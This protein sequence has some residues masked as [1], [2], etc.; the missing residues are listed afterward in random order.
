LSVS[1]IPSCHF[2]VFASGTDPYSYSDELGITYSVYTD[3][4]S[5]TGYE[6]INTELEIPSEICGVPVTEI[7]F[8]AFYESKIY[9]VTLPETVTKIGSSAF[10]NSQLTSITMPDSITSI[11]AAAFYGTK[12]RSLHLPN[13][14]TSIDPNMFTNCDE[15]IEVTLPDNLETIGQ[16]AFSGCVS[17]SGEIMLPSSVKT[18]ESFAFENCIALTGIFFSD[19]I[20]QIKEGAFQNCQG[21][22]GVIF[23]DSVKSIEKKAFY[24]CNN[25]SQINLPRNLNCLAQDAFINTKCWDSVTNS[26]QWEISKTWIHDGFLIYCSAEDARCFSLP[27]GITSLVGG[28]I[29]EKN[30]IELTLPSTVR[31]LYPNSISCSNLSVL[32]LN[33]GLEFIDTG[34]IC[35]SQ[36]QSIYIPASVTFIAKDAFQPL[37]LQTVYGTPGTAAQQFAKE[38]G[39]TFRDVAEL[40]P[41]GED[42]SII[43][44][45]DTWSLHNAGAYFNGEYYLTD[46]AREQLREIMA[47][48]QD[49]PDGAWTGECYGLAVSMILMKT[50]VYSPSQIQTGAETVSE[51]TSDRAVQSFINYYN[52]TQYTDEM[53]ASA[54]EPKST[55]QTIYKTIQTA[56]A[57][58]TGGIPFLISLSLISG[59]HALVGYGQE[60][61]TW[62]FDGVTYDGRILIWDPNFP[63]APNENT[64]IYYDSV[65]LAYCIPYYNAQVGAGG[66]GVIKRICDDVSLLNTYPYPFAVSEIA[67]DV[68][69]NFEVTVADAVLLAQAIA[70]VSGTEITAAGFHNADLDNDGAILT[71]DL[72]LLLR[73]LAGGAIQGFE[74]LVIY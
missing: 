68:D 39:I 52:F 14:L 34:A 35:D 30:I 21:L 20:E 60:D 13:L 43:Y 32:N 16:K 4:A 64:Y 6:G 18:I 27:E 17:L 28:I 56:K 7:G 45:V 51:I 62:E 44:G 29:A 46:A 22:T 3:H 2:Q 53:L 66:L 41:S 71:Y 10:M 54:T 33:E 5:V 26:Q 8:I 12:L 25:L 63:T 50:G 70:E 31:Y 37:Q 15:L 72:T 24:D 55:A 61:G 11:Q 38:N 65:T 69:C 47:V 9:S 59:G 42:M 57:V 67:G 58:K 40:Q 49:E 36:L 48:Y 1:L 23:P 19:K 74:S 73:M